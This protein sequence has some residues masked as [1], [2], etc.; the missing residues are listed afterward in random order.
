MASLK[1]DVDGKCR[2]ISYGNEFHCVGPMIGNA[3]CPKVLVFVNGMR[4]V[5][6]SEMERR[7]LG[8]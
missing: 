4:K 1:E 8:G 6:V 2:R 5:F 7:G 3:R